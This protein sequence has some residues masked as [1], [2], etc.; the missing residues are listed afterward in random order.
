MIIGLIIIFLLCVGCSNEPEEA[1]DQLRI[2]F[3]QSGNPNPWFVALTESVAEEAEKQG[4]KYFYTDANGEINRHVQNIEDMLEMDLDYL[5]I[6]PMDSTGL[7]AVLTKAQEMNVKVILAGR[8]TE[9]PHITTVY[10]DQVWEGAQCAKII[11]EV[12]SQARVVELRGIEGTSSV[13]GR[14]FGF[15]QSIEENY[16]EVQIISQATA[17]FSMTEAMDKMTSIIETRGADNIDVV[18]AHNDNMALGAIQAIKDAGLVPGLDIKVVG[19]DGQKEVFD[20]IILGEMLATVQ[21][22]PKIGPYI[23]E[24]VNR[25]EHGEDVGSESIVTD[26]IIDRLNVSDYYDTGF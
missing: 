14:A 23:F 16:P 12:N 26:R 1:T 13:E 20:A 4:V 25:I 6:A 8:T 21:C 2:G 15:R 3:A 11:G 17:N 18:F 9:G 22:S 24:V 7:K 5:I 10:S 19:I